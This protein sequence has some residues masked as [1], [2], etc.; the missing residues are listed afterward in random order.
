MNALVR[1]PRRLFALAPFVGLSLFAGSSSADPTPV[2]SDPAS[3][4]YSS[5][6]AAPKAVTLSGMNGGIR[7][8]PSADGKL[9]VRVVLSGGGDASHYRVVSREEAGGVAVCV[10]DADESPDVCRVSGKVE[11]R[12]QS[13]HHHEPSIDLVA[14]VPAGVS[15]SASTLNGAIEARGLTGEVRA[16][17]L[18]GDV[19][20]AASR[21]VSATTLNGSVDATFASAP[22]GSIEL[23]TNNGD[24]RATF[25]G[26]I[27]ADVEAE[28]VHG[29]ISTSFPMQISTT[30]GG[31]GPKSGRAHVGGGGA[32]IRARTINGDVALKGT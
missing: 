25:S 6:L 19:K 16:A 32:R 23:S 13:S 24:V 10:L 15:L 31:F 20:V 9:D 29:D 28:T 3:F 8:E 30:P 7:A 18:N 14:R 22:V 2:A 21:V 17:T 12:S 4:H 5:P 26:H 11:R 27:D 1:R